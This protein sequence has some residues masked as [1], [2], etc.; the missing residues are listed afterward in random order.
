VTGPA[1]LLAHPEA[2]W[3]QRALADRPG[4][5]AGA[6][7][8]V[9]R[10]AVALVLRPGDTGLELLFIRRADYPGDPWSGQV[11][12]P[13]GRQEPHDASLR[14]TALRETWEETRVDVARDGVVLGTLDEL[15]P[16]TP[17]LPP[18]VVRPYVAIV[19]PEVRLELSDE[20]AAA[21]W[22][23]LDRLRHP[24]AAFEATVVVRG[25]EQRV[26]ALRHA[27][28]TI[29]GMTERIFRDFLA[30]LAAA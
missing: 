1:A 30:R 26:P 6:G 21:F 18:I 10:A 17:V 11:A 24:D 12:F 25:E 9:R 8:E 14:E 20:V 7:L 15:W 23:P 19:T 27:D 29:W 5:V 3:L 13:G 28:Y 2:R 16:R 22:A 4:A